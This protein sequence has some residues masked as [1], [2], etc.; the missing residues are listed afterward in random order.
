MRT[1]VAFGGEH[2]ELDRFGRAL[3]QARRGGVNLAKK[4]KE[5]GPL[6]FCV[7][8]CWEP[9]LDTFY[10]VIDLVDFRYYN[11]FPDCFW[12]YFFVLAFLDESGD[13]S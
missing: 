7:F 9:F 4:G 12:W 8:F 11:P 2:K 13:S 5:V 3:V 10:F 6:V 1:V